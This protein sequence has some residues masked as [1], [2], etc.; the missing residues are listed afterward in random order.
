MSARAALREPLDTTTEIETPEHVRFRYPIA[1]PAKRALAYLVDL[2]VR[3][4]IVLVVGLLA[5]LGGFAAGDAIGQAS[6]GVVLVVLFVVEWVYYV[7]CET[8]WSGRTVGKRAL[9][10]RVVTEGGHPL[11]FV[12]ILLRNLLRAA[13]FLPAA[14]AVGL[15]V[16]ARD[17]RFRRL[18]DLA[19]GTL[20]VSESRTTVAKAW[21]LA[22]PPTPAELRA[23]PQRLPLD[24][25]DLDALELFLRRVGRLAPAR[26]TELAELVAPVFA[27]RLGVR[28]KDAVRFLGLLY[29]RA[30]EHES[31]APAS[32]PSAALRPTQRPSSQPDRGVT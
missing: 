11:S 4:V 32:T 20:V 3:A 16:M 24:G 30:H 1:G 25:D 23:L 2:L 5:A 8:L 31:S 14:Y 7:L 9:S 15:V 18:G 29:S 12:D 17:P 22:P 6:L 26:E 21:R 28:Y 19:A 27:A 10:L 13:D